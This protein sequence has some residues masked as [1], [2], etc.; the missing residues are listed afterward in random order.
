MYKRASF[1]IL[2]FVFTVVAFI[3]F[4]SFNPSVG[5]KYFEPAYLPADTSIKARRIVINKYV[6]ASVGQNFRTEDWVY[7]I[8]EDKA[9]NYSD[10]GTADQNY[11]EKSIKPTCV[12]DSSPNNMRYRICHWIDYGRIDV[13]EASFIK[14]GTF[15]YSQIPTKTSQ[16]ISVEDIEKYIDSF[17]RKSTF[18]LPVLR[19]NG[20]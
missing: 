18:G 19:S 15:I 4:R 5:F 7:S 10:I 1:G 11:D 17:K 9:E 12:I 2:I 16:R 6:P 8:I 13:H 20:P 14:E 3:V